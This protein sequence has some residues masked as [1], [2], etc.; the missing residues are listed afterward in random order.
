MEGAGQDDLGASLGS[1]LPLPHSHSCGWA[2]A[3]GVLMELPASPF[4]MEWGPPSSFCSPSRRA[5]VNGAHLRT[6]SAHG[7]ASW[8]WPPLQRQRPSLTETE[9]ESRRGPDLAPTAL[10]A[11]GGACPQLQD[12]HPPPCL[13]SS[14][15]TSIFKEP[16][17]LPASE[18]VVG[19]LQR[20][21]ARPGPWGKASPRPTPC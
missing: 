7:P 3:Y 14:P 13:D 21:G 19:L 10:R 6:Q 18:A 5:P 11:G 16:P 15:H 2:A 9:A 17:H 12:T 8:A 1:G 20:E 4:R